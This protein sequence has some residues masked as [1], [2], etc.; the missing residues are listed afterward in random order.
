[1]ASDTALILQT[2]AQMF[3][4]VAQRKAQRN[5]DALNQMKLGMQDRRISMMEEASKLQ[6]HQFE[7]QKFYN[8]LTNIEKLTKTQGLEIGNR[9][10][11][12]FNFNEFY[13]PEDENWSKKYRQLLKGEL[14]VGKV[15]RK[16]KVGFGFS[17]ANASLII[18]NLTDAVNSK[19]PNPLMH[20]VNKVNITHRKRSSGERVPYQD[21]NLY[22]GFINMGLFTV[23]PDTKSVTPTEDMSAIMGSTDNT[24]T[25]L[26][27]LSQEISEIAQ[28]DF[29]IDRE[30]KFLEHTALP[31]I[32]STEMDVTDEQRKWQEILDEIKSSQVADFK[33]PIQQAN[34]NII[35]LSNQIESKEDQIAIDKSKLQNMKIAQT[36]GLTVDAV[37]MSNL[38][39]SIANNTAAKDSLFFIK[40][41]TER[42]KD[43]NIKQQELI[44]I[45]VQPTEENVQQMEKIRQQQIDQ[46]AEEL[47]TFRERYRA[48]Q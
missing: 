15:G 17:D 20:L 34:E 33:T 6:K 40:R 31:S 45:G 26:S 23:D 9:I 19:N 1:M 44:D 25:N 37:D 47:A 27:K 46:A 24:L 8:Q 43:L 22:Q 38:A 42:D 16:E 13:N 10:I 2:T 21:L 14:K 12:R 29:K 7:M 39:E 18:G 41:D 48:Q 32:T 3:D 11:S 35:S 36:Q 28:N 30:F 5:I 4:R